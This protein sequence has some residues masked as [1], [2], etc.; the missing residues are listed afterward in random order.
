MNVRKLYKKRWRTADLNPGRWI[1]KPVQHPLDYVTTC[2]LGY[3]NVY[4]LKII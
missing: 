3:S 2:Y 1:E 4:K